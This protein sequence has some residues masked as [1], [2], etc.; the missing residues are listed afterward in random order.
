[1]KT[2]RIKWLALGWITAS[3]AVAHAQK[4][5]FSEN[6]ESYKPG[7][8][9]SG[10]SPKAEP[11]WI[12]A[13]DAISASAAIVEK[14]RANK[15]TQRLQLTAE[16][17]GPGFNVAGVGW[18]PD[19]Q[20]RVREQEAVE[21]EKKRVSKRDEEQKDLAN[22]S[23][24]FDLALLEGRPFGKDGPSL[25]VNIVG[26]KTGTGV[27]L[28]P[29]VSTLAVGG[30]SKRFTITLNQGQQY[31]ETQRL[32]PTDFSFRIEFNVVGG[33]PQATTQKLAIDNIE[34]TWN[35]KK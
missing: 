34:L 17:K 16:L 6:F 25:D 2:S 21:Q 28:N 7:E 4:V 1:M 12:V 3:T 23:V 19:Q 9:E 13:V 5:V 31:L 26:L 18:K 20:P 11:N 8:F 29:D 27:R 14:D 32:D 22:Y 33:V 30:E 15:T 35:R 24:S 10:K